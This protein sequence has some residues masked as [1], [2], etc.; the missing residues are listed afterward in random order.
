[1]NYERQHAKAPR[2]FHGI[3]YKIKIPIEESIFIHS[4]VH[5]FSD[6]FHFVIYKKFLISPQQTLYLMQP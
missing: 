3:L 6:I 4:F 2:C 5:I 1:M